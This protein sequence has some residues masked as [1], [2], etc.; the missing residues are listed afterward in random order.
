ML[1]NCHNI[2]HNQGG[3]FS[4]NTEVQE[5]Y[6]TEASDRTRKHVF[7]HTYIQEAKTHTHKHI[8]IYAYTHRLLVNKL[9]GQRKLQYIPAPVK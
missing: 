1:I 7:M 9:C 5:A 3:F 8:R 2:A 4:I 6:L